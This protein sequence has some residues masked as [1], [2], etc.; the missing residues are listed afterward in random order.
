VAPFE[1]Q[2]YDSDEMLI[3]RFQAT[4]SNQFIGDLYKKYTHLVFGS[5]MKYLK[6]EQESK[7]LVM[8]VFEKLLTKLKTEE[9]RHFKSWLYIL[10][11]NE[12]LM[13][14]RSK[15]RTIKHHE[16]LKILSPEFMELP[17]LEHLNPEEEKE[18]MLKVL[19]NGIVKLNEP[20]KLCIELF[21]LKEMSYQQVTEIT[22]YTLP[23]VK[24]HLQNGKRNLKIYMERSEQNE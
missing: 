21:F 4:G 9:V 8:Q 7:D 18:Q 16:N 14:L 2:M 13:H 1:N 17:K 5:C 22:G 24:S 10:V 15:E 19:E 3:E 11:K 12:C 20:Q 6:D 23:E